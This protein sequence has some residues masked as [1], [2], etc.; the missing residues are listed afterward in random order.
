MSVTN[1]DLQT[2]VHA[3]WDAL[4]LDNLFRVYWDEDDR[5][6]FVPLYD[7]MAAPDQPFPYCI[8]KCEEGN[9]TARMSSES[10]TGRYEIRDIPWAFVVYA[11]RFGEHAAKDI[12]IALVTALLAAFGG[13]PTIAPQTP[14]L[15]HGGVLLAQY[16]GDYGEPVGE[17]EYRWTIN[18][19][20]RLDTPVA[21]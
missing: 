20:F 8:Y 18:Y 7:S 5:D 12:A 3:Q 21:A 6:E 10:D 17:D 19:I 2:A 11:R 15:T 16:Q 13:H 4:E 9:T 1:A 14:L